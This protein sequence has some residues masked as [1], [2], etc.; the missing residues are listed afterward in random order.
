M[1]DFVFI[2][3]NQNKANYFAKLIGMPVEHQKADLDE[4]QSLDLEEIVKHK[5]RQAY[6]LI[7]RPVVVE[8]VA[9]R[10]DALNRLPG[11]FI[12]WF[13]DEIGLERT[14]QLLEGKATRKAV[15]ACCYGYFDGK[16]LK[17]FYS[18]LA[19]E[20]SKTPR[21]DAGF[22]WNPIFIP[23]GETLTLG[24]MDDKTFSR[25]YL[26][27]KPIEALKEFLHAD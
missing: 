9:L 10:F 7:K 14:C 1:K 22:G 11:P 21:G 17:L 5:V 23:E 19:G 25:H 20:V 13:I 15:A 6:E 24:E 2:T 27:I 12:K 3:G 26:R 8:D 18:E 16:E 4:I